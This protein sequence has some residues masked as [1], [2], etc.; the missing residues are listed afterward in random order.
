MKRVSALK[1]LINI[2]T[3]LLELL[4]ILLALGEV[5]DEHKDASYA[6]FPVFTRKIT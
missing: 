5:I 2:P 4:D 3:V 6:Y 1:L